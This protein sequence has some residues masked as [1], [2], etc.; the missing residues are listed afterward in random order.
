LITGDG[1]L[2][3]DELR[4]YPN[5]A[6]NI[7]YP[8]TQGNLLGVIPIH[9]SRTEKRAGGVV[10]IAAICLNVAGKGRIQRSISGCYPVQDG[11]LDTFR[12]IGPG[13]GDSLL[14]LQEMK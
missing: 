10:M 14:N 8:T 5:L 6:V 3:A 7:M 9:A 13:I 12:V 11:A 2:T 1:H 4:A